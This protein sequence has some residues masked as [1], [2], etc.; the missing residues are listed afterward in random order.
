[1]NGEDFYEEFKYALKMLGLSWADMRKALV[2]GHV[3][4][5]HTDENVVTRTVEIDM[6]ESESFVDTRKA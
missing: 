1:M 6:R 4:I 2:I 5:T 3:K